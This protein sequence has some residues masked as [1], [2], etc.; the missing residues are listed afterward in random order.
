M[1]VLSK[2]IATIFGVLVLARSY[3]DYKS[4]KESLQMTIFW[5]AIWLAIIAFAYFPSLIEKFIQMT[6]G[7]KTGLGTIFG[8]GLVFILFINYRIYIKANRVEKNLGELARKAG[9]KLFEK[10][11]KKKEG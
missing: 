8:I 9:L 11:Q 5:V 1:L 2:V 10:N 6:G 4:K 3:T 7:E